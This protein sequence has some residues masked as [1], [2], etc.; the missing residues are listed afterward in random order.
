MESRQEIM[1][2]I[3]SI[4]FRYEATSDPGQSGKPLTLQ[5]WLN[6]AILLLIIIQIQ[7]LYQIIR[8]YLMI[9]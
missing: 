9:L 4:K 3:I 8:H 1:I 7:I 5:D 2:R 6:F